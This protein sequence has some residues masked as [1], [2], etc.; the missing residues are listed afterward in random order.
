MSGLESN[1]LVKF[2]NISK[3]KDGLFANFK[4]KGIRGGVSFSGSI[5]VDL[6][7]ADVDLTDTLDKVVEQCSRLVAKELKRAEFQLESLTTV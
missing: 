1:F 6:S 2:I 4:V 7:A 3:R 5:S